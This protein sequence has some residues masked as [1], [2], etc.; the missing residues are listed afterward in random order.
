MKIYF[1]TV[2]IEISKIDFYDNLTKR[3]MSSNLIS[4]LKFSSL[5]VTGFSSSF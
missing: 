4:E 3:L 1:T 5:L 2:L